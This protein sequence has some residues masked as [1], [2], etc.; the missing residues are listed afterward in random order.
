MQSKNLV[1][2]WCREISRF[3][4]RETDMWRKFLGALLFRSPIPDGRDT[5]HKTLV[6]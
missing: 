5:G 4:N 6:F 1:K 2:I 3:Q